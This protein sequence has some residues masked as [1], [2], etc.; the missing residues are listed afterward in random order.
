MRCWFST[1]WRSHTLTYTRRC[2]CIRVYTR[3]CGYARL[4]SVAYDDKALRLYYCIMRLFLRQPKR[5]RNAVCRI[6]AAYFHSENTQP[7]AAFSALTH[8]HGFA[9]RWVFVARPN[10]P[11][12]WPPLATN[13]RFTQ[14]QIYS[15]YLTHRPY[16]Y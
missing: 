1:V 4:L 2:T 16:S 9:S 12:D 6:R 8:M 15:R 13:R 11:Q 14:D 3:G 7:H 10:Y 5:S